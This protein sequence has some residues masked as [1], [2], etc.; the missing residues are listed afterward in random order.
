MSQLPILSAECFRT[1]DSVVFGMST[2]RGGV[3]AAPYGMNCSFHV[4][5]EEANVRANRHQFFASLN[6]AQHELAIPR[7][8]HSATVCRADSPGAYEACDALITCGRKVFLAVSVADC[9]PIFLFDEKQHAVAA[10]HAGWRGTAG[11]IVERTVECMVTEFSSDPSDLLAFI[12]PAAG[13]CCY[14][15]GEDVA[16]MF[17]PSFVRRAE[18]KMFVDLKA[19]NAAQLRRNGVND[20]KIEIHPACTICDA[21]HF[22]SYRRDRERSGRMIGVIGMR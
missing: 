22:H 13:V 4:G 9:V 19:A 11:R 2:R 12:G 1:R 18:D 10:I 8:V 17:A 14:N 15:V 16:D 7:Q 6:I 5:D 21:E 3:S 20:T